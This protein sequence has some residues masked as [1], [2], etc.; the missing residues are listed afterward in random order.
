MPLPD[1]LANRT[2][3]M[4]HLLRSD[5]IAILEL[6]ETNAQYDDDETAEY[7]LSVAERLSLDLNQLPNRTP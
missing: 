6:I 4:Q 2:G 3:N 1:P 7:W 5:L